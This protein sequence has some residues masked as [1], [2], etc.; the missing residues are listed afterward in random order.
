MTTPDNM[1]AKIQPKTIHLKDYQAAPYQVEHVHLTFQLLDG[2]TIVTSEV[3]YQKNPDNPSNQLVLN[4][5][6]QTIVSVEKDGQ[7]FAGYT[8]ADDRMTIENA[9]EQL[10]LTIT[11]EIDP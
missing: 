5:Q 9:G 11:T 2:K 6:G 1:T 8:L 7:L 4:G 3:S 10:T